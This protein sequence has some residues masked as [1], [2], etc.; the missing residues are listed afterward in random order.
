MDA[1]FGVTAGIRPE[2]WEVSVERMQNRQLYP[3]R[4]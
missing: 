4:V 3:I 2:D 1:A